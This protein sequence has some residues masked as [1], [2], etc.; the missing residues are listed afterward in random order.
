MIHIFLT[1]LKIFGQ[2][3]RCVHS[4]LFQNQEGV[5]Q[6]F[7]TNGQ[8]DILRRIQFLLRNTT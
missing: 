8:M 6:E 3:M 7:Q 4:N 1:V 2:E 5:V